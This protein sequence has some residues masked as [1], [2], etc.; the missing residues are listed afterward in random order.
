[1]QETQTID[2]IILRVTMYQRAV[3]APAGECMMSDDAGHAGSLT[4]AGQKLG[5][6]FWRRL[7]CEKGAK[8]ITRIDA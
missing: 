6:A 7:R 8:K 4:R 1:M 5:K 2:G 3:D